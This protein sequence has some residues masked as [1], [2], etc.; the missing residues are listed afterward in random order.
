M[1]NIY[2]KTIEELE[3]YL[4]N[5]DVKAFHAKQIFEWLYQKQVNDFHLMSNL[6]K[7]LIS[8]IKNDFFIGNLKLKKKEEDIDVNK[9]LFELS[10]NHLIE[11]VLMKHNYGN[12]LCVSSQI[13]CNMGCSFCE[14]GRLK[15]VR[16]LLPGEMIEQILLVEQDINERISSVVIMGIGE[17]FDNYDNVMKF[18]RIINHPF[19]LAIGAR[20]ITISTCGLVPG[21]NKFALEPFQVNLALSLHAPND[22]LRLKLMPIASVYKLKDI[23]QAIDEYI[24]KTNRR[25]TIEYL[26]LED[27]NDTEECA[28]ELINLIKGKNVYVNLIPYNVTSNK[29]YKKSKKMQTD[30]FY[31]IL[32]KNKIN[33]TTRREFGTKITAACGQLRASEVEK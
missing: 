11:A 14:S 24:K 20:H 13:G 12:S 26:L 17:P 30:K 33:V 16:D 4:L 21:I 1:E 7:N 29:N 22:D 23:M 19:G 9:Y 28:F 32:I 27:I 18:I 2:N 25:V 15:K 10:D 3:K 8:V 6:S 5:Q 31:D